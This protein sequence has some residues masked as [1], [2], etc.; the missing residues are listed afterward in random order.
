M[1]IRVSQAGGAGLALL[2]AIAD[3]R[4]SLG[5]EGPDHGFRAQITW[6]R[7]LSPSSGWKGRWK[8]VRAWRTP[9]RTLLRQASAIYVV[10]PPPL[11]RRVHTAAEGATA[12]TAPLAGT[13]AAVRVAEGDEVA[14]GQLLLVL[15]AMKMEH[16]ITAPSA[17]VVKAVHV[18]E[19]DVVRE[20][21]TLL[22]LA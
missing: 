18:R 2:V 14:E 12:I 4:H 3:Q 20:G 10:P 11:P 21:D 9:I 1:E 7:P 19:R 17:G 8:A 6:R 16:R 5:L 22:E 13:I 15:E